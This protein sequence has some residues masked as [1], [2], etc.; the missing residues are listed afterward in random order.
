MSDGIDGSE[1]G[2]RVV[3][4]NTFIGLGRT[5]IMNLTFLKTLK[6]CK[7]KIDMQSSSISCP[8]KNIVPF[9]SS[10]QVCPCWDLPMSSSK[11]WNFNLLAACMSSPFENCTGFGV[12]NPKLH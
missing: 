7:D 1:V 10:L 8:S 5:L 9:F 3:L 2:V 4:Y 11:S 6:W 12:M